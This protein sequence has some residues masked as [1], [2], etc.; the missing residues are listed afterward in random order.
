MNEPPVYLVDDNEI[1][2]RSTEWWLRGE[3][4]E[5][6]S[7]GDGEAAMQALLALTPDLR[8]L[9]LLLDVRMPGL[10]GPELHTRLVQAG[11]CGP[12]GHLPV[13]YMTGH[14]EVPLAVE[15]M[16]K[17]A[18]TFLEKPVSNDALHRALEQ[19]KEMR[20]RVVATPAA[21]VLPETIS[22]AA[23]AD[24]DF[25]RRVA[26]LSERERQVLSGLMNGMINKEIARN[27][28]ISHKTVEL[29]RGRLMQKLEMR[30]YADLMCRTMPLRQAAAARSPQS[31]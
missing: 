5:V 30:N 11:L 19:A 9:C 2:R 10:S 15:A 21:L 14:G 20:R 24:T 12:Q 4:Y 28:G 1:F 25:E 22:L 29:Y 8:P 23:E 18:V 17:G 27:L 7:F 3:G 6:C 31:A 13:I 26:A 16:Q